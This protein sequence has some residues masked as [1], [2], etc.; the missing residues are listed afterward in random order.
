MTMQIFDCEQN[1]EEWSLARLGLP[2][3]SAFSAILAKGEGKTRR[4]YLYRLASEIVTGQPTETFKSAA[5]DRGHLMEDD[6]RSFYAFM[7]DVEPERVGFIR[8]GD[9]GCSPDSLIGA[10]GMLEIKTQ[11]A[12][13]LVETILADKFPPEHVA[14]TQGNLWIAEREWIDLCV[15]WPGMPKFVKRA[16][17]DEAYI[18][19][20]KEEVARFN[21][22]IAAT[23]RR[24]R[25]YGVK[26][27]A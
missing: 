10:D 12:D 13:L 9:V 22:D 7:H 23:V 27:S 19:R 4:A 8:N 17:R 5:M 21:E 3:A 26:E 11:R 25:A 24:I 18:D 14:Q 1:S 20:L 2:T 15:F 6:A 16:V